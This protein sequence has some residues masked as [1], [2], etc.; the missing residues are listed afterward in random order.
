MIAV[1]TT[2]G[3]C[4]LTLPLNLPWVH[5]PT[6]PMV[7]ICGIWHFMHTTPFIPVPNSQNNNLAQFKEF[8]NLYNKFLFSFLALHVE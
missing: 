1:H 8:P 7:D 4:D 3:V 5:I 2:T 6:K